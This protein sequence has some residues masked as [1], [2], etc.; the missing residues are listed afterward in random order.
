MS[1]P[2]D[3]PTALVAAAAWIGL[4]LL[5]FWQELF[6]EVPKFEARHPGLWYRIPVTLV[7]G[8][9]ILIFAIECL[10]E[11]MTVRRWATS[12]LVFAVF[13]VLFV[14][15]GLF[16]PDTLRLSRWLL[17]PLGAYY[18]VAAGVAGAAAKDVF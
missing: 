11:E 3:R 18:L 1:R 12:V 17:L 10:T 8:L 15:V 13:G 4:V 5:L 2:A 7:L 9:V 16:S 6:V 14:V